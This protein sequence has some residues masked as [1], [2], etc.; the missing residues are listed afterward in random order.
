MKIE[1]EL[2]FREHNCSLTC[3]DIPGLNLCRKC[4]VLFS[5]LNINTDL[6]WELQP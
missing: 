3:D 4:S 1:I 5:D 2:T 6:E